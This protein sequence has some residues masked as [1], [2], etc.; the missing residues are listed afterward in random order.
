MIYHVN[1]GRWLQILLSYYF[2]AHVIACTLIGMALTRGDIRDTWLVNIPAILDSN[3]P[4]NSLEGA[5]Y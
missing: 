1:L 2:V 4:N 3:G 5:S